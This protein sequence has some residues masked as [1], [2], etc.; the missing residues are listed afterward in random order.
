[1]KRQFSVRR[2][3]AVLLLLAA[4]FSLSA[5]SKYRVEMSNSTQ[6][7]HMLTVG[8]EEV[9]FELIDFFYHLRLDAY[10]DDD[11]AT[12]M[13]R[14]ED[15]V[16]ELYAIFAACRTQNL[17]PFGDVVNEAVEESVKEMIDEFP[18]RR[19]YIDRITD[20]HMTDTVCRLLL[21]STICEQMLYDMLEPTED[22]LRAFCEQE[23]V[24]RVMTL[25]LTYESSMIAWAEGRM[26]EIL[27]A[28]DG[29]EDFLSVAR[30]L[31]TADSEHTYIT[32]GQWHRLCGKDE[33]EPA[34][35]TLSPALYEMDSAL[36]MCVADK[37]VDYALS[38]PSILID[39]Y[40]EYQIEGQLEQLMASL[41]KTEAYTTLTEESF[42]V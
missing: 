17:D 41:E 5:C 26:G 6:T 37:D 40:L 35:G 27:A 13:A 12:R 28:L 2:L 38:H 39:S 21:R 4:V 14:V 7:R 36:L 11:H 34:P 1:M 9:A 33:P 32:K 30:R 31:A 8:G 42:A 25:Q 16:C 19:D 23:D 29:G 10:P 15:D 18:T 22:D 3:I 24:I 20:M